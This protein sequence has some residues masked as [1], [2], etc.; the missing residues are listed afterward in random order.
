MSEVMTAIILPVLGTALLGLAGFLGTQLQAAW[1]RV[2]DDKT[3]KS[4]VQTCVGAV[5]QL[6]KELDGEGKKQKAIE[7]I[8][9]MLEAK[10]IPITQLEIEQ[11]L[12]AAVAAMKTELHPTV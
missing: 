9:K 2:A 4:V 1:K 8:S 3:K 7:N 6:Y 12:E 11:L 10:N 5:E